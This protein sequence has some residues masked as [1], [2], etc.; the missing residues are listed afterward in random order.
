M[1]KHEWLIPVTLLSVLFLS[2]S[3]VSIG[4]DAHKYRPS[5]QEFK[6]RNH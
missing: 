3:V 4:I 6:L 2:M 1:Y 5:T